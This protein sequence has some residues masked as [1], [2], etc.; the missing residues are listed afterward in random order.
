M[1][2]TAYFRDVVREKRP[3]IAEAWILRVMAEPAEERR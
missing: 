3:D 2:V 1:K